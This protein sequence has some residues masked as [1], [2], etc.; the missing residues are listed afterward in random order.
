[1]I[2]FGMLTETL[3]FVVVPSE[4]VNGLG[5]APLNVTVHDDEFGA[6]TVAGEQPRPESVGLLLAIVTVDPLAT[7]AIPDP[8]G[9]ATTGLRME[10]GDELLEGEFDTVKSTFASTPSE[11]VLVFKLY[12]THIYCPVAI[13]LQFAA[14]P[15]EVAAGPS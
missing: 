5:A 3:E 6:T 8:S 14:L 2:E 1:V 7:P 11:I 15:P 13:V 9:A 10:T 12:N 4:I